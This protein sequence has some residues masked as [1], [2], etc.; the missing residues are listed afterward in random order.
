[1]PGLAV[2]PG[3]WFAQPVHFLFS[4][5]G[6]RAGHEI[7]SRSSDDINRS[8]T[9]YMYCTPNSF[10]NKRRHPVYSI[11]LFLLSNND[12]DRISHHLQPTAEAGFRCGVYAHV[13][14]IRFSN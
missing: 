5:V 9:P 1:M 11:W 10:H 13:Y 2:N 8:P 12:R 14:E 3:P 4:V 7:T 6:S